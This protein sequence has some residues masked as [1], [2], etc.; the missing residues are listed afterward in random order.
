MRERTQRTAE[1]AAA[2]GGR[3]LVEAPAFREQVYERLRDAILAGELAPGER[4][5]TAAI[6]KSFGVSAMPVRDAL[7]LLEQEGLVETAARRWTRVVE[8]DP[9][10]VEEIVPLVALLE[11]HA[12]ESARSLSDEAVSGLRRTNAKFAEAVA[13][14]DLVAC[15]Q[16]DTAFHEALVGLAANR[17]VER[18]LRD[19][20]AHVRLLRARV[21][22]PEFAS[23]SV[24]DHERII[25]LLE[26]GDRK[27]AARAVEANW[28]R[29]LERYRARNP[30][31]PDTARA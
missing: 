11:H 14:G 5:S 26:R 3:P 16:A 6:A 30:A 8:L 23:E 27:E 28:N 12:V 9:A 18:A 31:G 1:T 20:W 19:A 29:G 7:R 21:L 10:L 25:E 24:S 17:S 22:R 13:T 2:D 15:I 4:L